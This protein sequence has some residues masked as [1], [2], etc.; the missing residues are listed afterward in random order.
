MGFLQ[1]VNSLR[2][3][4]QQGCNLNRVG[5]ANV[6]LTQATG[7]LRDTHRGAFAQLSN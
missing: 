4:P 5:S 1:I 2:Q 7:Q 6:K 3:S